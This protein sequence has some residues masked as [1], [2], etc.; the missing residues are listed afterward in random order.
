MW[1]TWSDWQSVGTIRV[2]VG[3]AYVHP[4]TATDYK[5]DFAVGSDAD[6][7]I[8]Y[9]GKY[10]RTEC[11][12]Q[13]NGDIINLWGEWQ[14]AGTEMLKFPAVGTHYHSLCI[15]TLDAVGTPAPDDRSRWIGDVLKL[16]QKPI[17][18]S[19]AYAK[20]PNCVIYDITGYML[21]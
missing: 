15:V 7:T 18:A 5:Y 9:V 17:I 2:P 13:T 20:G 8:L 1:D 12:S 6:G 11:I 14:A 19:S 4:A 10:E 3:T 21:I 16:V